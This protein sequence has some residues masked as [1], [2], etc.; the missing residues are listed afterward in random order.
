M[1]GDLSEDLH[2]Y[3]TGELGIEEVTPETL[4]RRFDESFVARRTDAWVARFYAFLDGRRKLWEKGK[5]LTPPLRNKP[6]IR[7]RDRSH[8]PPFDGEGYPRAWLP[9]PFQVE[10]FPVVRPEVLRGG[11][12]PLNFLRNLGLSEPDGVDEVLSRVLPRYAQPGTRVRVSPKQHA[13]NLEL[14]NLALKTDS[15]TKRSRLVDSLWETPFVRAVNPATGKRRFR[16][17]GEVYEPREDLLHY[18]EG[19]GEAWFLDEE[20]P[21]E[22]DIFFAEAVLDEVVVELNMPIYSNYIPLPD[23][24]DGR[25]RRGVAGFDP[26]CEVEGLEIALERITP[27][28]AA[29][30]WGKI[31]IP[32][33]GQIRGEVE[34]SSSVSF[35][36]ARRESVLS[37]MGELVTTAA[38]LPSRSNPGGFRQP[39][40][41]A[42][43]DLPDGF[44]PAREL[45]SALGMRA[46]GVEKFAKENAIE[47]K[48]L[49]LFL[50]EFRENPAQMEKLLEKLRGRPKPEGNGKAEFVEP[51]LARAF[52]RPGTGA[53][54]ID[55]PPPGLVKNP[56]KL[57]AGL[58]QDIKR[59]RTEVT[60]HRT[61]ANWGSRK[62]AESKDPD[63]R[64]FLRAEYN[65]RC[66]ICNETFPQ[67]NGEPYFEGVYLVSIRKFG[68]IDY[69][70]NIL[71]LCATC[72]AKF[73]YGSVEADDIL[74][75]IQ[76]F[77]QSR[78]G[79]AG[80]LTIEI[81]L[82][83]ELE[84]IRFTER[85]ALRLKA[86]I[87][88]ESKETATT[89]VA[90]SLK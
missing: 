26:D 87:G 39:D 54:L 9:G 70:G 85:H 66:Q 69:P 30:I 84:R 38:W 18:F 75:Q 59:R 67:R 57:L 82:C 55:P 71:C 63:T 24:E 11:K 20:R 25:H 83:G 44:E 81:R 65:G 58:M 31:L 28:K 51:L 72:A 27:P 5:I 16:C 53:E 88:S 17:P 3:L 22:A 35:Q 64:A 7:L 15:E 48:Y 73:R 41:L 12:R 29:Y 46:S 89:S 23:D 78:E 79:S 60:V 86:M 56:G 4:A 42:L 36:G 19:N 77:C 45:A 13:R 14:I 62:I 6:F 61:S 2:D 90:D 32:L 21:A 47:V 43:E 34:S 68:W 37:K 80:D 74:G 33:A 40:E 10:E 52:E 8:V 1:E 49:D 76:T 50:K